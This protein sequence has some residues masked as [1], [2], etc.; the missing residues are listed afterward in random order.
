MSSDPST[1]DLPGHFVEVE[2]KLMGDASI[3][4][5][6]AEGPLVRQYATSA[7]IQ[8]R[9]V[10]YYFDTPEFTLRDAFFTLRVRGDGAQWLQGLKVRSRAVAGLF[11]REEWERVVAANRPELHALPPGSAF[12]V[13]RRTLPRLRTIFVTRFVRTGIAIALKQPWAGVDTI[14]EMSLDLGEIECGTQSLPVAEVELELISG[15]EDGLF[16]FANLLR[17]AYPLVAGTKSKADRGFALLQSQSAYRS[18][19]F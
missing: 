12:D 1:A 17:A 19:Q 3:L 11:R 4:R 6:I 9:L 16:Q 15:P 8:R 13:V 7:P 5:R 2:L 18:D 14:L 10:N